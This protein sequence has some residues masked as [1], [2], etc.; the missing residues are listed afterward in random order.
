MGDPIL[1]EGGQPDPITGSAC[2]V[3]VGS[4][5]V[6]VEAYDREM[7]HILVGRVSFDSR[8]VDIGQ[9]IADGEIAPRLR[10]DFSTGVMWAAGREGLVRYVLP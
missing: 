7:N 6:W 8:R 4:G 9:V 2:P 10:F 5:G 1:V 3:A